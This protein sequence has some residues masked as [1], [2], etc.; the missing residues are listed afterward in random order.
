MIRRSYTLS[1][2][3]VQVLSN[4]P[5]VSF[6][7]FWTRHSPKPISLNQYFHAWIIEFSACKWGFWTMV[8]SSF[9]RVTLGLISSR[10][11]GKVLAPHIAI[12]IEVLIAVPF[13]PVL[14]AAVHFLARG[15]FFHHLPQIAKTSWQR[16]K[17]PRHHA[18]RSPKASRPRRDC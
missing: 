8:D 3:K 5:A 17:I 15:P 14:I 7:D 13:L 1:C 12:Y 18:R 4:F 2:R 9:S 11:V 6:S 10:K 16:S